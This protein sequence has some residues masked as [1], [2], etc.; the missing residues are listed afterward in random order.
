MSLGF[1]KQSINQKE[2]G[3]TLIELIIVIVIIGIVVL[4]ALPKYYANVD[5]AE[6]SKV[7]ASLDSIRQVLL[8]YYAVYG[9]YPPTENSWPITVSVG[10]NTVYSISN[11]DPSRTSWYYE[12]GSFS[13]GCPSYGG[14]GTGAYKMPG[15]TCRYVLCV[16]GYSF[17]SCTP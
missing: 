17:Q 8:A 13:S 3:F 4:I 2:H 1:Y 10:G 12:H 11:P 6:K 7:Y 9:A 16:S 15:R 14:Y 5:R